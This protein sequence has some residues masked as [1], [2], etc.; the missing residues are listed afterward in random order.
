MQFSNTQIS[1]AC[2]FSLPTT[3]TNN[4]NI[5][6]QLYEHHEINVHPSLLPHALA[7]HNL[8]LHDIDIQSVTRERTERG[9]AGHPA[10]HSMGAVAR[11]LYVHLR[12]EGHPALQSVGIVATSLYVQPR[13]EG[14]PAWPSMSTVARTL[15][16]QP[17]SEGHP[18]LQSVGIVARSLYV[19]PRAEG[20]LA[21]HSV[22]TT[23][24]AEV[25]RNK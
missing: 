14:H 7:H 10:S 2:S 21:S 5:I 17:R 8:C 15:Y 13:A 19:Q 11:C 20:H 22:D 4:L 24:L 18:A 12:S 23:K 25:Q 3:D 1:Q 9:C 16:V 6:S